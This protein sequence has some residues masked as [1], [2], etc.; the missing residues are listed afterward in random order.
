MDLFWVRWATGVGSDGPLGN[1]CP[2][3][4]NKF[5]IIT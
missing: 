5:L 2:H 1:L 3:L 4:L